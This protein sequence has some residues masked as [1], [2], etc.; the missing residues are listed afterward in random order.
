[1]RD[2]WLGV[3]L[4]PGQYVVVVQD[5]FRV[6]HWY[7][8]TAFEL[9]GFEDSRLYPD[10]AKGLPVSQLN[11][12]YTFSHIEYNTSMPVYAHSKNP[13]VTVKKR[14]RK[15]DGEFCYRMRYKQGGA[16]VHFYEGDLVRAKTSQYVRRYSYDGGRKECGSHKV[17]SQPLHVSK[18]PQNTPWVLSTSS[19]HPVHIR[20]INVADDDDSHESVSD[21]PHL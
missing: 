8:T 3:V 7:N 1:M 2:H 10:V 18:P 20:P 5:D 14:I 12:K 13:D 17:L 19:F 4:E 16:L 21:G 15:R 11:G 9:S 6:R